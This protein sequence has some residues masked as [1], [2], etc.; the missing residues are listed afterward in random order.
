[1]DKEVMQKANSMFL[2]THENTQPDVFLSLTGREE[3]EE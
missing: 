1:M 3:E 2:K